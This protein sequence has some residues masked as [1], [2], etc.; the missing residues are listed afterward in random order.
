MTSIYVCQDVSLTFI[1][2]VFLQRKIR[3]MLLLV[4]LR[5]TTYGSDYHERQIQPVYRSFDFYRTT[6]CTARSHRKSVHLSPSWTVLT[7]F[8]LRL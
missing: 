6:L 7:R 8:S 1:A 4:L 2:F 5:G 3:P